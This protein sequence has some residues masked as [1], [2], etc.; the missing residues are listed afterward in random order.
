MQ[1]LIIRKKGDCLDAGGQLGVGYRRRFLA[2]CFLVLLAAGP[3]HA[4]RGLVVPINVHIIGYVGAAPAGMRPEAT[5][6]LRDPHGEYKLY[7]EQLIVSPNGPSTLAIDSTLSPYGYRMQVIGDRE[8]LERI[9]ALQPNQRIV[10]DGLL[11]LQAT[12][13]F[14]MLS[15]VEVETVTPSPVP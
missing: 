6:V 3:V 7:I 11:R 13:R 9:R 10:I 1:L 8:T 12:A 2:I 4:R 5:W 15:R 14:L